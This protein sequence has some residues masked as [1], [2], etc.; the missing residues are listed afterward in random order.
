MGPLEGHKVI[1]TIIQ[2]IFPQESVTQ[3]LKVLDAAAG[4]GHLTKWLNSNG[5]NVVPVDYDTKRWAL[6]KIP[7]CRV[8]LN[9][10]LP[11]FSNTFDLVVSIETIEHLE[12]PFHV[13]REFSRVLKSGGFLLVATPN[14]HCIRSRLKYLVTGLSVLFEYSKL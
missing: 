2:T 4:N 7:C 6:P 8:D 14:I 12:N 13:L 5:Y 10:Q 3:G 11:F 9:D 1:H